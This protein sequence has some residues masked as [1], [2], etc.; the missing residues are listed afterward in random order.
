LLYCKGV[1]SEVTK[2]TKFKKDKG[3]ISREI[4][5]ITPAAEVENRWS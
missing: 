4:R 3:E 2:N 1:E 5:S